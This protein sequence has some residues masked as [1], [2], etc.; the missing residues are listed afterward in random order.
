MSKIAKAVR[1]V[2]WLNRLARSFPG[3]RAPLTVTQTCDGAEPDTFLLREFAERSLL[4]M[5]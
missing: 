5:R 1:Q 3:R 4:P 2:S